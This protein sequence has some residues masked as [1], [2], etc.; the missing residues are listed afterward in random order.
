MVWRIGGGVDQLPTQPK[1]HL[2]I[3]MDDL[4]RE[5]YA[6]ILPDGPLDRTLMEMWITSTLPKTVKTGISN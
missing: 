4:S 6:G 5:L 2:F 3:A 1:E